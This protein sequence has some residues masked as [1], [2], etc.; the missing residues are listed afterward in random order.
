MQSGYHRADSGVL[1]RVVRV[2]SSPEPWIWD[3]RK[4][5]QTEEDSILKTLNNSNSQSH[6][7]MTLQDLQNPMTNL[8][9]LGEVWTGH[10]RDL[11]P[12]LAE[13][14]EPRAERLLQE[15]CR[16][17]AEKFGPGLWLGVYGPTRL[18]LR[19]PT[20]GERQFFFD[21]KR[22]QCVFPQEDLATLERLELLS[23]KAAESIYECTWQSELSEHLCF[24]QNQNER[25]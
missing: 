20:F 15:T 4:E 13:R 12:I 17:F 5:L 8:T 18:T 3:Q 16:P 22:R 14:Y 25:L 7:V 6:Q 11:L 23:S 24:K 9:S 10:S 1:R 19:G 21:G 2:Y